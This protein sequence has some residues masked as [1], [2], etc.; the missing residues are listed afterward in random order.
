MTQAITIF[1]PTSKLKRFM[2]FPVTRIVLLV[3]A[4][5]LSVG[6]TMSL[7]ETIP[8]GNFR[9]VVQYL[10]SSCTVFFVYWCYVRFVEKRAVTELSMDE[11]MNELGRGLITGI[12]MV[13]GVIT[14]L[15]ATG[16]YQISGLN[17][18]SAQLFFPLAEMIFVGVFEEVLCRGILFRIAEESLGSWIALLISA[19]VFGLGHLPGDGAGILAIAITIIAGVFFAVAYMM[20][21][22]LWLCIGIHIGWNYTLGTVF[23]VVVSGHGGKGAFAATLAG[24]DWLTGG[25]YGLEASVVT[26]MALLSVGGYFLW[27]TNMH[28][29]F[30]A[31]FWTRRKSIQEI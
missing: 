3:F 26:M 23:S 25:K 4:I 6:M 7:A 20:T 15:S 8:E 1:E 14:F 16:I 2:M 21:R 11:S 30:V 12:A 18:P 10:M 13:C 9:H 24:P 28:E 19:L 31:P 27:R 29:R 5:A 22:R 17:P